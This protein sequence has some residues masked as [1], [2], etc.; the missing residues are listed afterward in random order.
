MEKMMVLRCICRTACFRYSRFSAISVA[1]ANHNH[2]LGF[3][4]LYSI[5]SLSGAPNPPTN[6]P[7]CG[8]SSFA[9][10]LG[11]TSYFSDDVSHMPV[12]TDTEIQNVFKDLMAASWDELPY[13]V[14]QDAKKALSKN[15]DDKTGQVALKN[16]FSAAEAVE[17][18]GDILISMKMKLDDSIE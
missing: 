12:V 16:V 8:R 11:S 13:S 9:L 10:I 5:S 15:T 3:R 4:N 7:S 14:V 1:A 6:F 2:H 18:F 17:E